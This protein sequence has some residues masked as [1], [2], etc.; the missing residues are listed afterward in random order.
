MRNLPTPREIGVFFYPWIMSNHETRP[1][2]CEEIEG[3]VIPRYVSQ[4]FDLGY[5]NSE[6]ISVSDFID[7]LQMY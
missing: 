7:L 2:I 1:S 4:P 3:L 6:V 5:D